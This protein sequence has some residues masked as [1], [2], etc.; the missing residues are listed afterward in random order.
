MIKREQCKMIYLR[1]EE[2]AE[3]TYLGNCNNKIYLNTVTIFQL[4]YQRS[5]YIRTW[6]V[7]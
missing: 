2:W 5:G 7:L 1:N 6:G 4:L 3:K